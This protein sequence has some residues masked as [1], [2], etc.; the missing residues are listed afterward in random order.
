MKV[1][2]V[3]TFLMSMNGFLSPAVW[4]KPRFQPNEIVALVCAG[5][6]WLVTE[7]S[8]EYP[9]VNNIIILF[10]VVLCQSEDK[11]QHYSERMWPSDVLVQP[12]RKSRICLFVPGGGAL[13]E[14]A[15]CMYLAKINRLHKGGV[16]GQCPLEWPLSQPSTV[17]LVNTAAPVTLFSTEAITSASQTDRLLSTKFSSNPAMTLKI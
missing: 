7:M 11:D 3:V 10:S 6:T 9:A 15:V 2:I 14:W 8:A 13:P 5:F 16:E 12:G 4:W 1:F 17:Q